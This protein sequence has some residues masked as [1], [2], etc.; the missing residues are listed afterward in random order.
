MSALEPGGTLGVLPDERGV[1]R[2]TDHV[3]EEDTV[4]DPPG[5]T[6]NPQD[7]PMTES[8]RPHRIFMASDL[9]ARSDRT[10]ARALAEVLVPLGLA[11][12]PLSVN[13]ARKL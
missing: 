6:P 4:P 8:A 11:S 9:S 7:L 2:L 3:M 1:V 5:H 13:E 12:L 10:L